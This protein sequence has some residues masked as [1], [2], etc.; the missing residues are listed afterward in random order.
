MGI[1]DNISSYMNSF[2]KKINPERILKASNKIAQ[3]PAFVYDE[4]VVIDRLT[5]LSDV[6]SNSGCKIL[7]SIK[8]APLSGLLQTIAEHVDG[9]SASS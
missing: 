6:R 1:S 9:F 3:T 5:A 7:Y 8:A 4:S 2:S